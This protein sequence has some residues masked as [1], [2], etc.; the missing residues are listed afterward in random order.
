LLLLG[1]GAACRADYQVKVE[2]IVEQLSWLQV[3]STAPGDVVQRFG[4]PA[5][6]LENGRILIWTLGDDLQPA[7]TPRGMAW[8][9]PDF[10]FVGPLSLVVV[11]DDTQHVGRASLVRLW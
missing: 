10:R 2:P 4:E 6:R 3:G 5:R 7:K 9:R 11:L 8:G 1:L